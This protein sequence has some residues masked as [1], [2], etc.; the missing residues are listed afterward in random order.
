MLK[1]GKI[2]YDKSFGSFTYDKNAH[3]VQS[4]DLYDLA[5]LSKTTGTLLAVMK[6]MIKANLTLL[7]KSQP[8]CLI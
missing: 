8:I 3:K 4:D 5:S 1:N 2:V 6:C 7:I